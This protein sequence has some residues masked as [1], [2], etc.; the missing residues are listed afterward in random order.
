MENTAAAELYIVAT[1]I[2]NDQDLSDRAKRILSNVDLVACEDTRVTGI[3]FKRLGLSP[4]KL[5]SYHDKNEQQKAQ[6]IVDMMI[7]A[8]LTVA[9]VSDAG[10]P[11]VSDPGYRVVSL[12]HE[13]GVKVIPVPGP[14]AALAL[15]MSS[16]LF[17]DRF[18]FIGFLAHKKEARKKEVAGWVRQMGTVIFYESA[19]RLSDTLEIIA[20]I[21]PDATIAIG[22]ELT[23]T[24]EEIVRFPVSNAIEWVEQKTAKN[25]LK[26]EFV[27]A[28]GDYWITPTVEQLEDHIRDLALQGFKAGKSQKELMAEFSEL[29]L[30]K[31]DLYALL[32]DIK[33][34]E[35]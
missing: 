12:A 5:T 6:E 19:N 28:C 17:T 29:G 35:N 3:L 34:N 25:T 31:S 14:C 21:W 7:D 33:K 4:P 16:G 32:L 9:V 24:Y 27:I 20:S 11:C 15:I 22:R 18:S 26:G 13:R 8:G 10:T 1:P 23:K 2:G 30:K